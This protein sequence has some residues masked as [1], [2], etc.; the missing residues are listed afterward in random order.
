MIQLIRY[1]HLHDIV[2]KRCLLCVFKTSDVREVDV[3]VIF[4]FVVTNH[5]CCLCVTINTQLK[6]NNTRNK[7]EHIPITKIVYRLVWDGWLLSSSRVSIWSSGRTSKSWSIYEKKNS[8]LIHT[9]RRKVRTVVICT[10]LYCLCQCFF[11]FY[12]NG[13]AWFNMMSMK[14]I[15]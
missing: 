10:Y 5:S 6:I 2:K 1:K 8:V 4:V 15:I 13:Y 14:I 12:H 3:V 7:M 11:H 9:V